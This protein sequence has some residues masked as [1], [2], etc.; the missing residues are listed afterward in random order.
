MIVVACI[1]AAMVDKNSR[2]VSEKN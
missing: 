1:S 2:P